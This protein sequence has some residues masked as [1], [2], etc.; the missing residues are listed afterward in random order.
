M[1]PDIKSAGLYPSFAWQETLTVNPWHLLC[2][3]LLRAFAAASQSLCCSIIE[4]ICEDLKLHVL[5]LFTGEEVSTVVLLLVLVF[6]LVFDLLLLDDFELFSV[7]SLLLI[8]FSSF[9]PL[10]NVIVIVVPLLTLEPLLI[11]WLIA[12]SLL[13]E[14]LFVYIKL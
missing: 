14:L 7:F 12:L 3:E 4:Y 8:V 2:N 1:N 10:L 9:L 6:V 11:D 13:T 5:Q